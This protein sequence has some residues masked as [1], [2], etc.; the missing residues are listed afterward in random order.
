M[1]FAPAPL[2]GTEAGVA[3]VDTLFVG[4]EGAL[5]A[6]AEVDELEPDVLL[7]D[8]VADFALVVEDSAFEELLADSVDDDAVDAD[9]AM[10][11]LA[12]AEALVPEVIDSTVF[13]LS[14]TKGA[15]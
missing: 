7:D 8:L 4:E 5:V 15:L 1:T 12:V 3:V 14:T 2:D 11:M 10:V 6:A 13:E 9:E